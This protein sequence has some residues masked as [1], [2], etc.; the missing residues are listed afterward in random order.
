[1]TAN[2]P[3]KLELGHKGCRAGGSADSQSDLSLEQFA[4]HLEHVRAAIVSEKMK[5]QKI[6]LHAR[7][8]AHCAMSAL[9]W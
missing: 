1:M 8:V 3:I 5:V 6:T 2:K 4:A 7:A 9:A